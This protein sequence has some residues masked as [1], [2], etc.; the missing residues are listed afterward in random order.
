M[1]KYVNVRKK[2]R[3]FLRLAPPP[4]PNQFAWLYGL[5][6]KHPFNK[7]LKI[8]ETPQI[9]PCKFAEVINETHII[10]KSSN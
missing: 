10:L 1:V 4:P 3:R 2:E 8:T 5:S 6:T 9:N 7:V